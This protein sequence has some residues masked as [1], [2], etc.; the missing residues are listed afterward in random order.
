MHHNGLIDV[1]IF[2][3]VNGYMH[4]SYL[5]EK[6]NCI[7]VF[8]DANALCCQVTLL[9]KGT[10]LF[11]AF[12]INKIFLLNLVQ[13]STTAAILEVSCVRRVFSERIQSLPS[14]LFV[15]KFDT[16]LEFTER[17]HRFFF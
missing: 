5:R 10:T 14:V 12:K 1:G 11:E 2:K 13:S 3:G 15:T 8:A 6:H 17:S 7:N 16:S 9:P 4:T